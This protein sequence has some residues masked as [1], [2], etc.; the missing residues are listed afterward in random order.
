MFIWCFLLLFYYLWNVFIQRLVCAGNRAGWEHGPGGLSP[1]LCDSTC[2][3]KIKGLSCKTWNFG[4]FIFSLTWNQFVIFDV[5]LFPL[6]AFMFFCHLSHKNAWLHHTIILPKPSMGC[7]NCWHFCLGPPQ[8]QCQTGKLCSNKGWGCNMPKI[9]WPPKQLPLSTVCNWNNWCIRQ[10]HWPLFLN[11]LMI[12]CNPQLRMLS[13]ER[14]P[15]SA[16][17]QTLRSYRAALFN[18]CAQCSLG[19]TKICVG[20][21][22]KKGFTRVHCKLV[23]PN[24]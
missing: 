11:H 22:T 23:T 9:P 7:N 2:Q 21:T 24:R 5:I 17:S 13:M 6:S 4:D 10:V 12:Y 8:R 15:F 18:R 19:C 14:N 3:N 1:T 20:C 16:K